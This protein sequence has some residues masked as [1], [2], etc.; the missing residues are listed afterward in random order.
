MSSLRLQA[1]LAVFLLGV[2]GALFAAEFSLVY[3]FGTVEVQSADEWLEVEIG[4]QIAEDAVLRLGQQS[5]A[6]LARGSARITL[7]QCGTYFVSELAES[8]RQGKL[9]G[10]ARV[11]RSKIRSL[12]RE[13]SEPEITAMGVRAGEVEDDLGFDWVDEEEEALKEGK[14]LLSEQS[15]E[16]AVVRFEEALEMAD[17]RNRALYLFYIAYSYAMAGKNGLAMRYLNEAV[18]SEQMAHYGDYVLLKGRL[19]IEGQSYR[20]ALELIEAFL[21]RYPE[22]DCAQSALFLSAFCSSRLGLDS[23][24]QQRLQRAYALDPSSDT[25]RKAKEILDTL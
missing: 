13:Q 24:A 17:E 10:I 16:E 20:E 1:I 23:E 6:E 9:W 5:V 7:S 4:E 18:P 14:A 12:F 15:Y 8:S 19:L 3:A 2:S 21:E 11:V 22:H 25:G